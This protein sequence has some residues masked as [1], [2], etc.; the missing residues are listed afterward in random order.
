MTTENKITI[1]RKEDR[2]LQLAISES[3]GQPYDLTG[4]TEIE[5]E[6]DK[7]DGTTLELKYTDSEIA[8]VAAK[9]GTIAVTI[10]DTQSADLLIGTAMDFQAAITIGGLIRRVQW[11]GLLTVVEETF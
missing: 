2:T 5:I 7:E 11:T 6:L 4:V 9:A 10:T 3:S 1:I 8:V